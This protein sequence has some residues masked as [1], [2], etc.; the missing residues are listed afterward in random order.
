MSAR[1]HGI[2]VGFRFQ[3]RRFTG[4][5]V[6]ALCCGTDAEFQD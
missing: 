1:Q 2:S 4:S 5:R 6:I 3:A